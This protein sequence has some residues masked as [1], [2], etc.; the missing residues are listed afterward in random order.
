MDDVDTINSGDPPLSS[1][2]K[3]AAELEA[4]DDE[5]D[6]IDEA[7]PEAEGLDG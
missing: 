3:S 5:R 2:M 7:S 4:A 1:L 6:G